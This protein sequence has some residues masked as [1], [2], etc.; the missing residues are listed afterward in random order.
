[1]QEMDPKPI[2][3][4]NMLH[5]WNKETLVEFAKAAF[6]NFKSA[7]MAQVNNDKAIRKKANERTNRWL[8]HRR[9]VI[10]PLLHIVHRFNHLHDLESR[11]ADESGALIC[12]A[13][14]PGSHRSD[15][16]RAYVG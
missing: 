13:A 12:R 2:V 14:W 11:S 3:L 4:Q 16:S 6:C 8:G 7:W 1:V 9:E 10:S 15:L 5:R